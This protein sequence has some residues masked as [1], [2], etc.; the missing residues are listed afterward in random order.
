ML[1]YGISFSIITICN[2]VY[3]VLFSLQNCLCV[4]R[5]DGHNCATCKQYLPGINQC[6]LYN[7]ED[8]CNVLF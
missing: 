7:K 5:K 1:N 8:L 3:V 6:S 2:T 4:Y